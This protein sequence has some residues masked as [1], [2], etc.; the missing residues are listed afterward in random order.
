MCG[1]VAQWLLDKGAVTQYGY[2]HHEPGGSILRLVDE[3]IVDDDWL[4]WIT[5][6]ELKDRV[7]HRD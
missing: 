5:G 7:D 1:L 4:I 3:D 6:E 2:L